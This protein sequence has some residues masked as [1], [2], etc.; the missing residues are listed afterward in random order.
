M[1][2]QEIFE[3]CQKIVKKEHIEFIYSNN[4]QEYC[5][6]KKF[7]L[8]KIENKENSGLFIRV[9]E[10]GQTGTFVITQISEKN[11]LQ[12]IQ[13]AKKIAKLK[14]NIKIN[15]LISCQRVK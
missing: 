3:L 10:N 12:G 7:D 15:D 6:I 8:E 9:I 14:N 11:I 4:Y 1:N 5:D 2:K 13:N